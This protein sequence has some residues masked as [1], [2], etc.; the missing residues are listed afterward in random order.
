MA[1]LLASSL[2]VAYF[3]PVYNLMILLDDA[4][5]GGVA[6]GPTLIAWVTMLALIAALLSFAYLSFRRES[7]LFRS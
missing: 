6:W 7:V 5:K 1:S 4:V 3:I 2:T